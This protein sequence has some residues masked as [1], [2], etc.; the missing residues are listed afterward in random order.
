MPPR[1]GPAS[2]RAKGRANCSMALAWTSSG[3]GTSWG[4]RASNEGEAK[5]VAVPIT[6][7]ARQS[8]YRRATPPATRALK[9]A[10]A[11]ART[12]SA[13]NRTVRRDKRS[14]T[15]P[16]TSRQRHLGGRSGQAHVGERGRGGRK[17]RTPATPR[18]R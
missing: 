14:E 15:A 4:T 1:A 17:W 18:P 7:P 9:A 16:P 3:P 11:R 13:Q 6:A 8:S 12:T 5:A 10:T 2:W